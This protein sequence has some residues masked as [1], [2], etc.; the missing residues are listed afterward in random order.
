MAKEYFVIFDRGDKWEVTDT[1]II[2]D[3]YEV[4]EEHDGVMDMSSEDM[5]RLFLYVKNRLSTHRIY[6][7]KE[8]DGKLTQ[9]DLEEKPYDVLEIERVRKLKQ[10]KEVLSSRITPV[11]VLDV[12]EFVI[13]NNYFTDKG[14]TI[15]NENRSTR[16]LDII[17]TGNT[18]AIQNLE[19]Y[20]ELRDRI[21]IN[22][23][24][25][26]MLRNYESKIESSSSIEEMNA[27]WKE[28]VQLFE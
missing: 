24:W 19:K 8:W 13:L 11:E 12:A 3:D 17:N 20:L 9:Q 6:I 10:G 16:Y 15:T 7:P 28:Y 22:Y 18:I 21:L 1:M 23:S 4:S 27:I 26:S 25:L 2:P 5:K 14:F